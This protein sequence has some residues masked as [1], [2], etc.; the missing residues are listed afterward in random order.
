MIV[1]KNKIRFL[2]TTVL[3]ASVLFCG[4]SFVSSAEFPFESPKLGYYPVKLLYHGS[5]NEYFN[6]KIELFLTTKLDD[7]SQFPPAYGGTCPENN[8]SSYC[9]SMGAID[10]YVAYMKTLD[11]V[12]STLLSVSS[13]EQPTS[14]GLNNLLEGILSAATNAEDLIK[15]E[16]QEALA[17][18]EATVNAYNEFRLAYP[19][20]KKYQEIL[21]ELTKYRDFLSDVRSKTSNFP[22]EFSSVTTA[23]CK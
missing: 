23:S 5:M 14:G 21:S 6:G 4:Y 3:T 1:L 19:M 16:R 11:N 20:H 8:V 13:T 15:K 18:M 12:T 9:V 17:A 10:R 22:A 2:I 7:P